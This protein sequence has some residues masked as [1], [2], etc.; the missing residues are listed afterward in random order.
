M[1]VVV[2]SDFWDF[3]W[4]ALAP[5]RHDATEREQIRDLEW[6]SPR[7]MEAEGFDVATDIDVFSKEAMPFLQLFR[8]GIIVIPED[9]K[10][11][12]EFLARAAIQA[13]REPNA[14]PMQGLE[15]PTHP[16]D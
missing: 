2:D 8:K 5:G 1:I 6:K 12:G 14:P 16:K 4:E 13:V 3:G 10:H 9:V 11:A 15:V 7:Q